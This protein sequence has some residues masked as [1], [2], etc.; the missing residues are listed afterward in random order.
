MKKLLFV[1][2]FSLSPVTWGAPNI[3]CDPEASGNADAFVYQEGTNPPV[4]TPLV[5]I[6]PSI[7]KSCKADVSGFSVGTHSL[8]VWF[9][10]VVWGGISP[11]APFSFTK[12]GAITTAP[13][14]LQLSQ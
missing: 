4:S 13:Q 5:Q 3:T 1:L 7:L 14:N 12:P 2:L 11:K 6:A 10:N 8:Q 9:S